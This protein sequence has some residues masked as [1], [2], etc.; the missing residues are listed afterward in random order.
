MS[1]DRR[2]GGR[3]GG[4]ERGSCGV[5]KGERVGGGNTMLLVSRSMTTREGGWEGWR[6]G[7]REG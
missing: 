5:M 3:E 4:R 7:W 6:G 2:E 1:R